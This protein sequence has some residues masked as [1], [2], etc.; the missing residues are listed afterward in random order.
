MTSPIL[1]SER[2]VGWSNYFSEWDSPARVAFVTHLILI[3]L[4][5]AGALLRLRGIGDPDYFLFDEELFAKNVHHYLLGLADNNDHPPLGKLLHTPGVLLFGY[6]AEGWRFMSL[7]FGL[8]SIVLAYYLAKTLFSDARA[9]LFA[10]ALVAGDGFFIAYSRTGL[11][12]GILTCLILWTL[13]AAVTAR[14]VWG[15]AMSAI[16]LGLAMSVKWSA[17]TAFVPAAVV[18]LVFRRVPW[19]TVFIFALT[20]MVH[21]LVWM[22]GLF[23]THQPWEPKALL[24]LMVKLYRHHLDMAKHSNPLASPWYTWPLFIHP[25]VVKLSTYGWSSRYASSIPNLVGGYLSTALVVALPLTAGVAQVWKRAKTTSRI[26]FPNELYKPATVLLAGWL[27][28]IF[29]WIVARGQYVFFYHY[30]PS[31]GFAVVLLA[32]VLAVWERRH[33]RWILGFAILFLAFFVFFAPVWGEFGT[34]TVKA[35]WRLL[36]QSWRP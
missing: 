31:Y 2:K 29:P 3:L 34:T 25:I 33:P 10:A 6:N 12:D 19:W 22:G 18:I 28:L 35:N 21:L 9:G 5:I 30:L 4:I 27:A 32:G 11:I 20:P 17:V 16:L 1:R 23:L 13:L 15:I 26:I 7:V 14:T 8:Q 36:F 24:A